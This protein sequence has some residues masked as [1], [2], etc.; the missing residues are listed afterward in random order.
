[1]KSM[2]IRIAALFVL[3]AM[4]VVSLPLYRQ[5]GGNMIFASEESVISGISGLQ[6]WID[7]ADLSANDGQIINN[8]KN[9]ALPTIEGVSDGASQKDDSRTG[10]LRKDGINGVPCV[11]F[12]PNTFYSI[13]GDKGFYLQ[14]MTV[15][16]VLSPDIVDGYHEFFSR[17]SPAPYDHN[18]FFNIEDGFNF[19]WGVS[20]GGGSSY[21]QKKLPLNAGT[22]YILS[23]KRLDG[24]GYSFLNGWLED[25]F[26]GALPKDTGAP[27][28]IGG[29]ANSFTGKFGELLVFDRALDEEEFDAVE[30]YL[31]NKWG[32]RNKTEGL[33]RSLSVNG[34]SLVGFNPAKFAYSY[35]CPGQS[36]DFKVEYETY[37]PGDKVKVE[38]SEG[39]ITV[40]VTSSATGEQNSYVIKTE[41]LRYSYDE[42]SDLNLGEVTINS[43]FWGD[44]I[45]QYSG[46]TIGY[47][48]D[49]FDYS[50]SFDNFDRVA[51][52]ERAWTST[53]VHAGEI[54]IPSGD[55]RLI[56]DKDGNWNWGNEPWRE[57]LIMETI[58]ASGNY[59]IANAKK[60]SDIDSAK[61]LRERV[62]AYVDRIYKAALST[63]GTDK[64]GNTI[65]GYFSTF[66]LLKSDSVFD[67]AS[68][69]AIWNHD[70]YNFGCYVEAGISWYKA[71]GDT[72]LLY[73][74]T[75]FAEFIVDYIYGVNGQNGFM[76]VPPHQIAEETLLDLYD[77]Y[78]NN[79]A[80]VKEME[81]RYTYP[82]GLSLADRYA[83]LR[84]RT[85][86]YLDIC[87]AWITERGEYGGRF[88][89]TTY[90]V[91]AQD[92]MSHE[93]MD[94]AL[95]HAV[96]ANLWY[97]AIAA[98][99]KY[100]SND[101]FAETALRIWNNIVDT[102]MYVS[103]GTGASAS[104]GEAYAGSYIL[105]QDGYCETCAS[106]GMAFFAD[107]M[108]GIFGEGKYADITELEIYNG[109][110]GSLSLEGNAFYY[111][112]PL[113]SDNYV[114]PNW[115][116]ATPCC[117]PMYMK[118]FAYL[119]TYIYA[120][121]GDALF[122]N[123]YI[124]STAETSLSDLRVKVVQGTDMPNGNTAEFSI[125]ADGE[126]TLKLR[127]PSWASGFEVRINGEITDADLGTDGYIDIKRNWKGNE[128]V[129]LSLTKE[130][131]TIR[132]EDIIYNKG[133]VAYQYGPFIYCAESVDNKAD[134]K[135]MLENGAF[136]I[137]EQT[138]MNAVYTEDMFSL[139]VD[140]KTEKPLGINIL[141]GDV[142][143]ISG[144]RITL[145]LVPFF[146]RGN[147]EQG[148]MKVWLYEAGEKIE[149]NGEKITADIS[150]GSEY[151]DVYGGKV[152]FSEEGIKI[153][154]DNEY[155]LIIKDVKAKELEL[156]YSVSADK[157]SAINSGVYFAASDP[158]DAQDK[159]NAVNVQIEKSA[160]SPTY[161]I[162]VFGFSV[163]GGYL[164]RIADSSEMTLDSDSVSLR[165]VILEGNLYVF[166]G[167]SAYPSLLC[168]LG[169]RFVSGSFGVRSMRCE[170]VVKEF[171]YTIKAE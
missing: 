47:I 117:P 152:L 11:E 39:M 158:S 61:A 64:K 19:G 143:W 149:I 128:T 69:G 3:A 165:C 116:G 23:G 131:L 51:R 122:V 98:I 79:P 99:G 163:S 25:S 89:N 97:S 145:T 123:Q 102:Q 8:M 93:E 86:K 141:K 153:P 62:D 6:I 57:G 22:P 70:L 129:Q 10:K 1:M 88:N 36:A 53:S 100:T 147:R 44:L 49:M 43:G 94:E 120:K 80:L 84:I 13:S 91:Y 65:D 144:E 96:R 151:F 48:F 136:A 146:A 42:I 135:D 50:H 139:R 85:D 17:L 95:G 72:R 87:K 14:D 45:D 83:T 58:Q 55:N 111:T 67:E 68:G 16:A 166:V 132:Q 54:L 133:Q 27:V 30:K 74:A 171:S 78:K 46:Y 169:G 28:L 126:F 2:F 105:P 33:L 137:D 104:L 115:S 157:S 52:G 112:N 113:V 26:K 159:I 24:T 40:T 155:K 140:E 31:E 34:D 109:I 21:Y 103:G 108:F 38:T 81:Q 164:G 92:H 75:R 121:T 56:G 63:T 37:N 167:N 7:A 18:W 5:L 71:T 35:L 12:D 73:V 168:N 130:V 41:S 124:S 150:R 59:I 82:D 134:G 29:S 156:V 148:K 101:S 90:G 114:R 138:V 77:L 4:A 106:V 119:P 162:A 32:I 9:K 161:H 60:R 127:M 76:T 15:F 154:S 125:F 160:N 142:A 107:N 66:N 20:F 110:L 118:V 170:T